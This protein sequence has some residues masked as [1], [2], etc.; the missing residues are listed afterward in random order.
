MQIWALVPNK[1]VNPTSHSYL[2]EWISLRG[3]QAEVFLS[4]LNR[5]QGLH[6]QVGPR[7]DEHHQAFKCVKAK[8]VIPVVGQVGHEDTY[9]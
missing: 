6:L 1:H 5:W 3:K 4:Q 8:A 9:L 2:P 7:L